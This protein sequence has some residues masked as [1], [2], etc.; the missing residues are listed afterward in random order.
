[1]GG[2]II[3]L[4]AY[5]VQD[6]YLT[7]DPQIT[8][9]KVLYR[10]HTS[11]AIES[12][13]Q[14]FSSTAN[15]GETVSCTISRSG[16]LVGKIYLCVDLPAIPIFMNN[17]EID[18]IK[19]FAWVKNLGHALIQEIIIEIGGKIIDR[20]YGEWMHIWSELT[21]RQDH[22]LNKMIGNI[23]DM[24]EFSNGKPGYQ[25]YI[26]LEFWFCK[27]NG[28]ALPL[29]ALSSSDIK[30]SVQFRKLEECYRI[31]PTH[32]IE[33]LEDIVPFEP[34]NYIEQSI[35]GETIY[36]Y[37]IEY[38]Y[39]QKKLFYI[40]IQCSTANKKFFEAYND[41][42]NPFNMIGQDTLFPQFRPHHNGAISN[43]NAIPN[44][45]TTH[46]PYR[47]YNSVNKCY[48]TPKPNSREI[49]EPINIPNKPQF[50]NAFLYVDYIYLE[51]NE[52]N[53]FASRN[54]EYLIEQVQFNQEIGVKSSSIKQNLTLNHPCKA[55]YWVIQLDNIVG[56]GTINDLF[57][58]TNSH[59]NSHAESI[60]EHANLLL[61]GR[62]RFGER[63]ATYTN[64]IE[65]YEHHY[66]SPSVGINVYSPSIYPENHQPSS[67]IN[68][69]KID[70]ITMQMRLKN[71]INP[72]NTAKIRSYTI[73]YNIFR[74]LYGMGAL[75]F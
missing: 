24:N 65:P 34:G 50:V 72:Q 67:A 38:D 53:K 7:G 43:D 20:Q 70:N 74:V 26:P 21:N 46:I 6:I 8:Y 31:G 73:N 60:M 56:P 37:V 23:S 57:N 13:A 19:K 29:I 30:I 10:R 54:H 25:L 28:L 12:V 18:T 9:F 40:K 36:G 14:Y 48:C 75:A 3:Q 62:S 2:A 16:D 69:S 59:I 63:D 27:N 64:L 32:S 1:M 61:N 44:N 4:V 33:I 39:I 66:R 71:T 17:H 35:N 5:G 68:M 52:R 41:D 55:H 22:A 51:T 49:I 11:F 42:K 45:P 58:Y 47:I 15:F